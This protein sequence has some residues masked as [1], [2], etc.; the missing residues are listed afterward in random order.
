MFK[1]KMGLWFIIFLVLLVFLALFIVPGPSL[2]NVREEYNQ[3]LMKKL[4]SVDLQSKVLTM[5]M[6]TSELVKRVGQSNGTAGTHHSFGYREPLGYM[7]KGGAYGTLYKIP[8]RIKSTV[9][10]FSMTQTQDIAAQYKMGIRAF[11][12]RISKSGEDFV[13]DHGA[14]FGK[15]EDCMNDLAKAVNI[16]QETFTVLV[17]V[18]E[19]SD[20]MDMPDLIAMVTEMLQNK[21]VQTQR[22]SVLYS[23]PNTTWLKDGDTMDFDRINKQLDELNSYVIA[24]HPIP[25][26][27]YVVG[28]YAKKAAITI[29]ILMIFVFML[30]WY[31]SRRSKRI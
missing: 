30:R 26:T 13:V 17:A 9:K 7:E 25:T 20:T 8:G 31:F 11:D 10:Q 12:V 18:S 14:I 6:V 15:L 5:D 24:T 16:N 3:S 1:I 28:D 2:D 21:G 29:P 23:I 4:E 22:F 19:Y 27:E